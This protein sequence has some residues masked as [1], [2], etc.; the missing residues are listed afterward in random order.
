MLT[1]NYMMTSIK[2]VCKL[3]NISTVS[4]LHMHWHFSVLLDLN[5]KINWIKVSKKTINGYMQIKKL[6]SIPLTTTFAVVFSF[7]QSQEYSPL[8]SGTKSEICSSHMMSLCIIWYLPP[9]FRLSV[10]FFHCTWQ[11][12][13]ESSQESKTFPPSVTCWFFIWPLNLA[14]TTREQTS[15]I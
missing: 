2:G 8:S 4:W 3:V 14:G 10:P 12:G 6:L 7:P 9:C 5:A 13:F 11:P 1:G 15:I